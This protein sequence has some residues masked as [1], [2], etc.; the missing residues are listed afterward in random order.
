MR[1]LNLSCGIGDFFREDLKMKKIDIKD[2]FEI[3]QLLYSGAVL[4]IRN[5][6]YR[7]FGGFQLWWYDKR[8]D[9]CSCCDSH[10]SDYRKRIRHYSLNTA[11][12]VLWHNRSSLFIRRKHLPDDR[13]LTAIGNS[14]YA[15]Q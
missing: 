4:G 3:K 8:L 5:D 10:W 15:R 13:K 2:K 1:A 11:A 12:K 6:Q 9:V 14:S 7:S